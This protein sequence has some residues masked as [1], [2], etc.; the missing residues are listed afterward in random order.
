MR[1]NHLE[2]DRRLDVTVEPPATHLLEV[3]HAAVPGR[4]RLHVPGLRRNTRLKHKLEY[5]L[6]GRGGV[7]QASASIWTGNLAMDFDRAVPLTAVL[8]LTE[9]VLQGAPPGPRT[10]D[11]PVENQPPSKTQFKTAA[12]LEHGQGYSQPPLANG[13]KGRVAPPPAAR[14]HE[15]VGPLLAHIVSHGA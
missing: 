14:S 7:R 6:R 13:N 8:A 10:L 3:L 5:D 2:A 9:A 15:D 1:R 11:A 4:V 12:S